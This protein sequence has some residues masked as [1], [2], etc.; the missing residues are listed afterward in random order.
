MCSVKNF[1]PIF[2][3]FFPNL[4]IVLLGLVKE[5]FLVPFSW[6][7][8]S[9]WRIL[10]H[11]VVIALVWSLCPRLDPFDQSC[12]FIS[13]CHLEYRN[14]FFNSLKFL[15]AWV[16]SLLFLFCKLTHTFLSSGA[17]WQFFNIVRN[18]NITVSNRKRD[19][20][21]PLTSRSVCIFRP[22]LVYIPELSLLPRQVPDF[23]EQCA[24]S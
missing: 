23:N 14:Y 3:S 10:I 15:G 20:D 7:V 8:L 11:S 17:T 12:I 5:P 1:L 13:F 21:S 16:F 19:L 6:V 4:L 18:P 22:R 24:S 9:R 2:F